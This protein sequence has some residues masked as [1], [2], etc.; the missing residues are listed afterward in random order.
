MSAALNL[1]IT[2][3]ISFSNTRGF[4]LASPC[5][6]LVNSERKTNEICQAPS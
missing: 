1:S 2:G 6:I 3:G 5:G 4:L